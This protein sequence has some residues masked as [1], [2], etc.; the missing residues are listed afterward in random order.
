MAK[1]GLAIGLKRFTH[2]F[3][4]TQV[5][6]PSGA[7]FIKQL[8]FPKLVNPQPLLITCNKCHVRGEVFQQSNQ[9]LYRHGKSRHSYIG[10]LRGKAFENR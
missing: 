2:T 5:Q 3:T 10:T 8:G 4:F 1:K 6:Q 7:T 9:L